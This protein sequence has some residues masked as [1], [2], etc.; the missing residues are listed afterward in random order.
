MDYEVF[1]ANIMLKYSNAVIIAGMKHN[2]G[3]FI[4]I[5]FTVTVPLLIVSVPV[6]VEYDVIEL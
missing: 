3:H 4:I 2:P 6:S 1:P 5:F